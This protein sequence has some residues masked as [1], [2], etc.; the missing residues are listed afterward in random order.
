MSKKQTGASPSRHTRRISIEGITFAIASLIVGILVGLVLFVWATESNQPPVL[1]LEQGGEIRVM[2]GQFYVPFI[3][4]N[5]GGGTAE[6]V[7][8]V[9][10]LRVNGHL[11]EAG[12]QEIEFLSR[13]EQEEGAFVFSRD[14][15]QGDLRLRVA[16]Y[17]LP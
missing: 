5:T 10:E 17:K 9:G 4:K 7:H 14:P 6:A 12:D 11:E 2:Q 13:G 8:L 16:S 15:R 1:M 3:V